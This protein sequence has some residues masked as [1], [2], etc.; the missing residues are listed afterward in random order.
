MQR[1]LFGSRP[2][3]CFSARKL[4]EVF[5]VPVSCVTVRGHLHLVL[6]NTSELLVL[7]VTLVVY[8]ITAQVRRSKP[9]NWQNLFF[10]FLSKSEMAVARS[11]HLC[12]PVHIVYTC[13]IRKR[14]PVM[15]Q[16]SLSNG[17]FQHFCGR[18]VQQTI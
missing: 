18:G 6:W 7:C 1:M 17:A 2:E 9:S 13:R 11:K 16:D 14:T 4:K 12:S 5:G 10:L 8:A 15:Q 3:S